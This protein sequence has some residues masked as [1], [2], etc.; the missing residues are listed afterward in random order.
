MTAWTI[1]LEAL[2]GLGF[3]VRRPARLAG[4]RDYL[5][6]LFIASTYALA[7]VVGFGWLL[8]V[9][10]FAQAEGPIRYLHLLYVAALLVLQLDRLPW[11]SLL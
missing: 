10:G 3:L 4:I 2:I 8:V 7:P 9:M 11:Q 6:L 1:G 5:L